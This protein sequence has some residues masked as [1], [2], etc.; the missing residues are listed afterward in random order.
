MKKIDNK[1]QITLMTDYKL[2]LYL[3]LLSVVSCMNAKRGEKA[4]LCQIENNLIKENQSFLFL[5]S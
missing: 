4:T 5:N 2:Y 3:C 1:N